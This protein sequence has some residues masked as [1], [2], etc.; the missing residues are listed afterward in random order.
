MCVRSVF[1]RE[2]IGLK[3]RE[4][5]PP[6]HV[7]EDIIFRYK[8]IFDPDVVQG[9]NIGEDAGIVR[10][11]DGFIVAHSDPIT[12][13]E[14]YIGWLAVHVASNDVAV[15]GV[16]PRWL[17]LTILVPPGSSTVLLEEIARDADAA[18]KSINAAIIGGHTE[19]TPGIPRPIVITTAIGFTRG[20][21]IRTCDAQPGD[22]VFVIGRV[23]G[24]GASVIASDFRDL[25][26]RKGISMNL[27]NK[28]SEFIKDISVVDKA[29]AI[30][31][32]VSAMH[33][34]TEG[35][36]LEALYEV[37]IASNNTIYIDL[38]K[39]KLDP[40]VEKITSALNIDPHKLLSSGSLIATVPNSYVN[41]VINILETQGY[42]YS[43]CGEVRE[44]KPRLI[45]KRG[46]EVELLEN[47][48]VD[49]IYRLWK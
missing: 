26:M 18:A 4:G 32:Y 39:V 33:D 43:Q 36:I 45:I 44:G 22:K 37:A 2:D 38:N 9:P 40:I 28:A 19:V 13:A 5:K 31:K 29:M 14:K 25:L 15:R 7:L 49:E 42:S 30:K 34:P 24:E 12:A 41:D 11:G 21:V 16:K 10:A 48:I 20:R 23:G 1:R 46:D 3:L 47:M 35:G 6:R 8:G 17:L 27:I